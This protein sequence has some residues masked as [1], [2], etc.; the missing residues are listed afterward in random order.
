M[1]V[2][3]GKKSVATLTEQIFLNIDSR[4]MNAV[5]EKRG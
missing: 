1:T 4:T 2:A 3:P 5:G